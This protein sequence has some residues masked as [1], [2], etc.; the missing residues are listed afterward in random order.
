RMPKNQITIRYM[1]RFL[2]GM[3]IAL[4]AM[5][6]ANAKQVTI[7]ECHLPGGKLVTVTQDGGTF[8]YRHGTAHGTDMTITGDAHSGNL[9]YWSGRYTNLEQQLRFTSGAYSYIVFSLA[10]NANLGSGADSGIEVLKN[11]KIISDTTGDKDTCSPWSD[12]NIVNESDLPED[13][14][15]WS[16]M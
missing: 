4:F 7:F 10:A 14:A 5:S 15:S 16:A 2:F 6:S 1:C 8:T 11:Q 13:D 9:F 3:A 12:L